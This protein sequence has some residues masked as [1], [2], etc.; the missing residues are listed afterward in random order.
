MISPSNK[1]SWGM[2]KKINKIP[3][4]QRL[5]VSAGMKAWWTGDQL[6]NTFTLTGRPVCYKWLR[7]LKET[8]P[9]P[10]SRSSLLLFYHACL[11]HSIFINL[12]TKNPEKNKSSSDARTI[13]VGLLSCVD[14]SCLFGYSHTR[15]FEAAH[16]QSP[17]GSESK[18]CLT[19]YY[20]RKITS[21]LNKEPECT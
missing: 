6:V 2:N 20:R 10:L 13:L 5:D 15:L 3:A 1:Q 7:S 12:K 8:Q 21:Q 11:Y 4:R 14:F 9:K 18:A 16:W 19:V 17:S